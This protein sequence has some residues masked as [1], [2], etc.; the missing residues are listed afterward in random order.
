MWLR[1]YESL[2]VRG[3][4]LP[5]FYYGPAWKEHSREANATML[6]SDDALLLEPLYVG[7]QFPQYGTGRP[8]APANGVVAIIVAYLAGPLTA[9]DRA[10]AE[11]TRGH[12]AEAGADLVAVFGTH[13]AENN[14]P[15]LPLRDEHVLVWVSRF[16]HDERY[17]RFRAALDGSPAWRAVLRQLG[18]RSNRLPMQHLRL[19]PS[20]RSQLR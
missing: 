17:A 20:D 14:S 6:D 3:E 16:S 19:R 13:D 8:T 5:G 1:G 7:D 2:A 9:S 18:A 10:L 4:A 12:L 15:A 11:R